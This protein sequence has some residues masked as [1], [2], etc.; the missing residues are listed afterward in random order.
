MWQQNLVTLQCMFLFSFFWPMVQIKTVSFRANY[1]VFQKY[2]L[3]NTRQLCTR[4]AIFLDIIK[5]H[6]GSR[7]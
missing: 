3:E 1:G 5:S 7:T 6:P 4:Q 2:F